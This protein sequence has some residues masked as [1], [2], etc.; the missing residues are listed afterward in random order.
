[1]RVVQYFWNTP[2][3][4]ESSAAV[5]NQFGSSAKDLKLGSRKLPY[6]FKFFFKSDNSEIYEYRATTTAIATLLFLKKTQKDFCGVT[7]EEI[8]I[9]EE[10]FAKI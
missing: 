1:M 9:H 4:F 10:H 7:G 8:Y 3:K 5:G 6:I 2:S